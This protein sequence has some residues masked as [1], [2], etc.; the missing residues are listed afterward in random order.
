MYPLTNTTQSISSP[1]YHWS[2]TFQWWRQRC[3]VPWLWLLWF[4]S[5][6]LDLVTVEARTGVCCH[7]RGAI[8]TNINSD[9]FLVKTETNTLKGHLAFKCVLHI[10]EQERCPGPYH[11]QVRR[12]SPYND[13]AL[14]SRIVS[15]IK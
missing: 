4:R 12:C 11:N 8:K 10:R 9:R 2:L 15:V 6:T 5:L 13:L 1:S 3:R 7:G 14:R